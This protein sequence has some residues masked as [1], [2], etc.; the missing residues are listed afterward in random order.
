[1]GE[2]LVIVYYIRSGTLIPSNDIARRITL[3]TVAASIRRKARVMVFSSLR[4]EWS[5]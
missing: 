3:A 2:A 5:W 1:M 4:I